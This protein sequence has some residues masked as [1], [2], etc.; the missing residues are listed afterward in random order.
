MS[1]KCIASNIYGTAKT[2]GL[3]VVKGNIDVVNFF[4]SYFYASNLKLK[5]HENQNLPQFRLRDVQRH[6][7]HQPKH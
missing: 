6:H 7:Y 5:N 2:I 4:K 3:L 1:Y